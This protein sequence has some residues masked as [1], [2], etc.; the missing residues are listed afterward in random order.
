MP[1][2]P[3]PKIELHVH[4][5]AT[6]AP[7]LL[8]KFARRNAASLPYQTAEEIEDFYA[9]ATTFEQFISRWIATSRT[10]QEY[11]DFREVV[12]GY[13]RR[14]QAQGVVYAEA[15]MSP[16]EPMLRGVPWQVIFEG[17]CDGAAEAGESTGVQI[18]L[19][20]DA[21]RD[22]PARFAITMAKWAVKYRDRGVVALS[23]GGTE[24]KFATGKFRRAF[25]VARDGGLGAAPH[26]GEFAGGEAGAPSVRAAL[27]VLHADRVRH[28][29]RAV[30]DA[31][32]L[33]ELA[34]R[35]VVCDVTPSSNLRLGAV[36]SLSQ[37]PLPQ[38]LAAG[39]SCS[40]GTDD[41]VMLGTDLL[42]EHAI[43]V[44]MGHSPHAM[45]EHALAGVLCE[46]G[47]R[48]RLDRIGREFDWSAIQPSTVTRATGP[49]DD[50]PA[51]GP[52]LE[53]SA[54]AAATPDD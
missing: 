20:P 12:L 30:D 24:R 42:Q 54:R 31:A 25:A 28:G 37:H 14:V 53:H 48:V 10:L 9:G 45:Y 5:E 11:D 22:L 8:L 52:R 13:A 36:S 33:A 51:D 6:V 19:T 7:D 40:I 29:I 26:A 18:R 2:A 38:M 1:P 17:Y 35:G 34:E 46:P 21:T 23:L 27:D 50:V 47:L 4:L 32:L 3:Y 15:I 39:V 41:P 16:T 43:A 44:G 49:A